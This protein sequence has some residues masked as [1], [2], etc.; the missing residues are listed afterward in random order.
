M[1]SCAHEYGLDQPVLVQFGHYLSRLLHGDLGRSIIT[2]E[3]VIPEFLALFPATI[4]LSLCAILSRSSSAC[5]PAS[6]R[7][8]G[9]I[10]SSTTA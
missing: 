1:R 8:C 2:H 5:R 4:E 7:R 10:P 3:P 6:S 9:A